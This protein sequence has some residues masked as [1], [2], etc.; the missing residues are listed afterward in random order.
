MANASG[1]VDTPQVDVTQ[2]FPSRYAYG[3]PVNPTLKQYAGTLAAKLLSAGTVYTCRPGDTGATAIIGVC[4]KTVDNSASLATAPV[5]D[6]AI[7]A[8]YFNNASGTDAVPTDCYGLD[9]YAVDD[10]TVSIDSAGGTRLRAGYAIGLVSSAAGGS[11]ASPNYVGKVIVQVA[12]AAPNALNS[13]AAGAAGAVAMS[14]PARAVITALGGVAYTGS[15]TGTIQSSTNVAI[16]TQDGQTLAVGDIVMLPGGT[17]A[18]QTVAQVD[19]GL[20][21]VVAL[22]GSAHWQLTRPAQFFTG[23]GLRPGTEVKIAAGTLFGATT[24]YADLASEKKIDTDNQEWWPRSVTQSVTLVTGTVAVTN[25]PIRST[26]KTGFTFVRTTANTSTATTGGYQPVT[27]VAGDL[28]TASLTID[29]TVAAGTIN[30]ADISTLAA[31]I[32]N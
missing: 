21:Q 26:T 6:I 19:A 10:N 14:L 8:F 11:S 28:G 16:G 1:P 3:L 4:L 17:S 23:A 29:A 20:W 32:L 31:T 12:A 7:G 30:A 9:V 18:S 2:V 24:W 27:I 5:Q 25:V 22:G 13:G 15:G